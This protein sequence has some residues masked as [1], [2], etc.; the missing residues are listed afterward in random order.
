MFNSYGYLKKYIKRNVD[1]SG[2][3]ENA[4][5]P[6]NMMDVIKIEIELK[7]KFPDQ[8]MEFYKE[9]GY[10]FLTYPEKF[11]EGFRSFNTNRI[12][13]P[14]L[15]RDIL[16][17]GAGSYLISQDSFEILEPGDLPFFEISDSSSFMVMKL[18]S[19][20]P[21]AVWFMGHEKIE[22]SFE[23]FIWRLYYED[24]SYYTKNW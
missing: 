12:N 21:N 13:P 9:I 18:N 5:Y 1:E 19:D 4:F 20:N 17:H 6:I 3:G 16:V 8:L 24:P 11:E 2:G 15:I 23:R 10:G 14:E 7:L 22:D